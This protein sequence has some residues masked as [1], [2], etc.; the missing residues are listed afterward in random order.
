MINRQ[1]RSRSVAA[2]A[3]V[4][5]IVSVGL[6]VALQAPAVVA[7]DA[8][9]PKPDFP[10]A[11]ELTKGFEKIDGF[12]PL[13]RKPKSEEL[14]VHIPRKQIGPLFLMATSIA[15]GP[16]FA[17]YQWDD[18]AVKWEKLDK[19]LLLVRPNLRHKAKKGTPLG[20]VVNRTFTDSVI[21]AIDIKAKAGDGG[22]LI[23]ATQLFKFDLTRVG[24]S[25][26]ALGG[27]GYELDR[28]LS[29]WE[30]L[31]GFE[32]NT[33]ISVLG[34]FTAARPGDSGGQ[35]ADPRGTRMLVH[36][37]LSEVPK[38]DYKP[39]EADARVGYF[40]TAVKDYEKGYDEKTQF[41][42]LINR[43]NLK[44]A[45][46]SLELSPPEKPI[47]YYIEKTVPVRFRRYVKEGIE[48]W[49]PAFRKVGFL[50]A[51]QAR[52]QT[53]TNEFAKYDPEDVRYNFFRWISSGT[54]FAMG[55]SR[56][57]PETGEILDADIIMDDAYVRVMTEDFF[58]HSKDSLGGWYA[59]DPSLA[60]YMHENPKR[61]P[62]RRFLAPPPGLEPPTTFSPFENAAF[63]KLMEERGRPV[64]MIAQGRSQQLH[65]AHAVAMA[66]GQG[67]IPEEFIGEFI[68]ET[69]AHEV[70]HTLGLRHNFKA[71]SWRTLDEIN[72]E[73]RPMDL[74]ASVMDYNPANFAAPGRKQGHYQMIDLG[75]YDHWAIEYGYRLPGKGETE[76]KLVAEIAARSNEPGHDYATDEDTGFSSPDPL[77]IRWDL[78]RDPIDF[79]RSRQ[80]LVKDLLK[81]FPEKAVKDGES[82]AS[83]RRTFDILIGEQ[84]R[85]VNVAA[86]LVGG[87]Y[88]NRNHKG[89]ADVRPPLQPVE[90]ERQRKALRFIADTIF[91]ETPFAVEPEKLK[92]LGF[93]RWRHWG[94][95]EYDWR[96]DYPLHDRILGLQSTIF[97]QLTS[98]YTIGR[99]HDTEVKVP[100]DQDVVTVPELFETL[101]EAIWSEL[102]RNPGEKK[103]TN[104]QPFISSLR[105]P[106]QREHLG[107]L[108]DLV[109][110]PTESGS[111]PSD[112]R[113]LAWAQL[114]QLKDRIAKVLENGGGLDAYTQ[115]HLAETQVR[116]EKALDAAFSRGGGGGGGGLSILF[117][118]EAPPR[119]AERRRDRDDD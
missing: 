14:Y 104:R 81:D 109:L 94:S 73:D 57:H 56:V 13:Y 91:S 65:I 113:T 33:E 52:Q 88:V 96:V 38:S 89:D 60:R 70:G 46:D 61:D 51:V 23:D 50:D 5:L 115:A 87:Q 77:T 47:V 72:S 59:S 84:S 110:G 79:A 31:K 108:I 83:A 1:S 85:A 117:G 80:E 76:E 75:P 92:W 63:M 74:S 100:S 101:R 27:R 42:R 82:F 16:N 66:K 2:L 7:E 118:R 40:I 8:P 41:R 55:P 119:N 54:P 53:E 99:I 17:G 93:G 10:P 26:T 4:A 25:L 30:T 114:R 111:L 11:S 106:F 6:G 39:R 34:T 112:A 69:V 18:M 29:R 20:D 45:D 116:I 28:R 9:K 12:Y 43:W 90:A 64:C 98:D 21:R 67:K 44:K 49:N 71:S 95:S 68:R 35:V 24:D 97:F 62:W 58:R 37:S 3:V 107:W 86:R 19:K 22:Y 48:M 36:Y 78:G 105:R 103:W 15:G 102:E 32:H